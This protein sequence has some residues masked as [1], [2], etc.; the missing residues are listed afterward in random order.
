MDELNNYHRWRANLDYRAERF[1]LDR[2][3]EPTQDPLRKY[4]LTRED[5][6]HLGAIDA[7]LRVD[8]RPI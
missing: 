8:G 7:A 3:P 5:R 6:A 4:T 1:A 2:K